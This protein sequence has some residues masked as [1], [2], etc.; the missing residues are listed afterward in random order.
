M[1]RNM[2]KFNSISIS[3]YHMQEAGAPANLELGLTIADG[4]EYVR[5]GTAG[6]V[7][8]DAIAPRFSFFFGIGTPTLRA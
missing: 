2:P 7:S 8:V 5:C 3:G 6:G 1:H 4:L